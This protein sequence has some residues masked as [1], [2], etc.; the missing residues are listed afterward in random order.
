MCQTVILPEENAATVVLP[1]D[2]YYWIG[3]RDTGN[4]N[5]WMWQ[6]NN[7]EPSNVNWDH[8][9]PDHSGSHCV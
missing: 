8:Y 9:Q 6:E 5:S 1:K 4:D 7:E 2:F 3:L